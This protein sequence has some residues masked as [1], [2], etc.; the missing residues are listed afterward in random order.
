MFVVFG[1]FELFVLIGKPIAAVPALFTAVILVSGLSGE[2]V[3]HF[4]P[5]LGIVGFAES[6]ETELAGSDQL[7]VEPWSTRKIQDYSLDACPDA[8]DNGR[9][10]GI[11][12]SVSVCIAAI[13]SNN[14]IICVTDR[15]ASSVEFSNEDASIKLR[16]VDDYWTA[17]FA[18]ND[19]SPC[20]P[21]IDAVTR[22]VAEHPNTLENVRAAFEQCYQA[23]L[24]NL[25]T[26]RHLGRWRLSMKE[27]LET[28]RKKFGAD[29]FDNLCAQIERERLQ[30]QFLVCGFDSDGAPHI[31]TVGNP[32]Y[33]EVKDDPGYWAIGNGDFA[34]MSIL[35]YFEQSIV[36]SWARTVCNVWS[37]KFMAE[38]AK[39]VG[40]RSFG[41]QWGRDGK[42]GYLEGTEDIVRE[43][44]QFGGKP[45]ISERTVTQ[46]ALL[47]K[48][49]TRETDVA[50]EKPR[51]EPG[52]KNK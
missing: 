32:G 11:G 2:M 3:A 26:A 45:S 17:M 33:S 31:F 44:W 9:T 30:C 8:E 29:I 50:E 40:E 28:G 15:K 51:L 41:V 1:L 4:I 52:P 35:G 47:E 5:S 12:G 43:G 23:Y 10:F 22:S 13:S 21:I 20:H 25:A 46:L 49:E 24:S 39:D 16:P 48:A 18:G 6:G 42:D 27:F 34:A 37:A 19:I 36:T 38:T 7:S 14:K